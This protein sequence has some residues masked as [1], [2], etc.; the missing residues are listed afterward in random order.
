LAL[1]ATEKQVIRLLS[2]DTLQERD[3]ALLATHLKLWCTLISMRTWTSNLGKILGHVSRRKN[4]PLLDVPVPNLATNVTKKILSHGTRKTKPASSW[5][6][7]YDRAVLASL[8]EL[9]AVPVDEAPQASEVFLAIYL[10]LSH[11]NRSSSS[12]VD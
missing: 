3:I 4:Q 10:S 2:A 5:S 11:E 12:L 6:V 8:H 7:L 1:E 9:S